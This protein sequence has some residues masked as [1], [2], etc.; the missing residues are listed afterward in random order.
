MMKLSLS[1]VIIA[2]L[3]LGCGRD[4]KPDRAPSQR[5]ADTR[6]EI[7]VT[8]E[9]NYESAMLQD[10]ISAVSLKS[11]RNI[12][13]FFDHR[14]K[15]YKIKRPALK[16]G[17]V[18]VDEVVFYFIDSALVKLRYQ[19]SRNVS[20]Y[21]LDSLGLSKFKPMDDHSREVLAGGTLVKRYGGMYELD[22][23]LENYELIWRKSN[24]VSRF[25]VS[26]HEADS[27]VTYYFYHELNGYDAKIRELETLYYV[28]DKSVA[29]D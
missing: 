18:P 5:A 27:I 14:L 16:M 24:T 19:V 1:L 12:G 25:R 23:S 26:S 29:L 21:L 3:A 4:Y 28:L 20:D 6:H 22:K 15:F 8:V 11:A 9:N 10:K 13:E 17:P 2:L 7:S